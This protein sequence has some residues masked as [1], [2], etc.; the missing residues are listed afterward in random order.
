M[1]G[2][3]FN[4]CMQCVDKSKE[5]V[6]KICGNYTDQDKVV[7]NNYFLEFHSL[8]M[9]GTSWVSCA[10]LLRYWMV[11]V[12]LFSLLLLC[13]KSYIVN[14]IIVHRPENLMYFSA[15]TEYCV[16]HLPAPN[17]DPRW[18]GFAQYISCNSDE[19][20]CTSFECKDYNVLFHKVDA[21]YNN[22]ANYPTCICWVLFLTTLG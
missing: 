17:S 16:E 5:D 1:R 9:L 7:L 18:K 22:S 15:I 19:V 21:A 2:T 14:E 11:I 10:L 6:M 13:Y 12:F 20:S 8:P 4:G 3:G